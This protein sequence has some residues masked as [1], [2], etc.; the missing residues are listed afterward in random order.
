M[1]NK[2]LSALGMVINALTDGKV[3]ILVILYFK[4][5]ATVSNYLF[6]ICLNLYSPPTFPIV[7]AS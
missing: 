1:I 5:P 4:M 6:S 7:T 3:R 2:S